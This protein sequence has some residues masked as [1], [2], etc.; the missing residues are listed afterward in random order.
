[1]FDEIDVILA[2]VP[3]LLIS[4]LASRSAH[5][6]TPLQIPLEHGDPAKIARLTATIDLDAIKTEVA[7]M[8]Q[9]LSVYESDSAFCHN[10]LLCKNIIY[11]K[12]KGT[13]VCDIRSTAAT[14]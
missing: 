4:A 9:A 12:E 7:S 6:C 8:R 10:D 5:A 11:D 1:M 3:L 2:K 14:L 13:C